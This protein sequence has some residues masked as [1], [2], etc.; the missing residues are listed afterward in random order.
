MGATWPCMNEGTGCF[1]QPGSSLRSSLDCKPSSPQQ[2]LASP[3]PY[4]HF[5]IGARLYALRGL[6]ID[7][8]SSRTQGSPR[9]VRSLSGNRDSRFV[10]LYPLPPRSALIS[11]TIAAESAAVVGAHA[12]IPEPC[13]PGTCAYLGRRTS[14]HEPHFDSRDLD[15]D[16]AGCLGSLAQ[17]STT[18]RQGHKT[19]KGTRPMIASTLPHQACFW[20]PPNASPV[21]RRTGR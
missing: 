5:G 10:T 6:G 14:A 4:R 3:H 15:Q 21:E 13:L 11:R 19:H 18:T 8:G 7:V 16:H 20:A 2:L 1:N 17:L 12:P 9:R